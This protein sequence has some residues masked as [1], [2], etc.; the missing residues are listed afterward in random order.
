M[1]EAR[2]V[3]HTEEP[4][5]DLSAFDGHTPG[6]WKVG[7]RPRF[8]QWDIRQ[9]PMDWDGMGYQYI[10]SGPADKKGTHYGD[11][12]AANSRLIAAAPLLLA[13]LR[14]LRDGQ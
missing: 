14:R 11:M 12:F 10:C 1:S 6:P 7:E 5:L 3:E 4:G 9:D 8:G 13:E 2:T